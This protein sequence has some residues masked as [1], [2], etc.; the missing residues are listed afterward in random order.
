MK[1]HSDT[2]QC[3]KADLDDIS[4]GVDEHKAGPEEHLTDL[5]VDAAQ[6]QYSEARELSKKARLHAQAGLQSRTRCGLRAAPKS[7]KM[8]PTMKATWARACVYPRTSKR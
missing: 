6:P 3:Q 7:E 5:T 8:G 1:L 2:R 4:E